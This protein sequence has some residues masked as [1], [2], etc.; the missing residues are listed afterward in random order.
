MTVG[1]EMKMFGGGILQW[2]G[3]ELLW[4][5]EAAVEG[6]DWHLRILCFQVFSLKIPIFYLNWYHL[7]NKNQE[8]TLTTESETE[9]LRMSPNSRCA[10][11][12]S[13][14]MWQLYVPIFPTASKIVSSSFTPCALFKFHGFT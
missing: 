13:H 9:N 3:K 12:I 6:T 8:T 14:E 7:K 4:T 1:I 2:C 11:S 5:K 10:P